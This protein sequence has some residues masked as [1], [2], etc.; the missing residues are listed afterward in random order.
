MPHGN[1]KFKNTWLTDE[2]WRSWIAPGKD[3]YHA[4][5][6]FCKTQVKVAVGSKSALKS[7]ADGRDH[8]NLM[9]HAEAAVKS[10]SFLHFKKVPTSSTSNSD[11]PAESP[12][13]S[14]LSMQKVDGLRIP[15][16]VQKAEIRWAIK[17]V[18]SGFSFRSCLNLNSLFQTMF[19]DSEIAK[20]FKMSKTKCAYL[21]N[22]GL[23]PNFKD[24]LTSDISLSPFFSLLFDES[25]NRVLQQEQMDVQIRYWCTKYQIVKSR[26]WDSRFLRPN[27]ENIRDDLLSSVSCLPAEKMHQLS[28]DGP[29]TNWKVLSLLNSKR[30]ESG[31]NPL[32]DAGSCGLHVV[33]GAFQVGVEATEWNLK[34]V[35][36]SMWGLLNESPARRD[37]Y[38][39]V[40]AAEQF[41]LRFCPTRWVENEPVAERAIFLW[42]DYVKLIKH[43]QQL[44]PSYRP[45]NNSSF[46]ALVTAHTDKFMKVKMQIFKDVAS[47]LQ[48]F[49]KSFQTDAPMMPFLPTVL[50][51]LL[52]RVMKLFI[53]ATVVDEQLTALQLVKLD[54]ELPASRIPS[55]K[56]KLLVASQDLLASGNFTS[57]QREGIRKGFAKLLTKMVKKLQERSPLKYHF[58]RC[59][60]S[61]SPVEMARSKD[62]CQAKFQFL[63][64]RMYKLKYISSKQAEDAKVQFQEFL[65]DDVQHNLSE[66]RKYDMYHT[67]LD[68]FLGKFINGQK[69]YEHL[70]NV[71]KFVFVLSH[72]QSNIERGFNVNKEMLEVNLGEKSLYSQRIIYDHMNA[73]G[74]ESHDFE[75][76]RDL[77]LD[78]KAAHSRYT[79]YLEQKK[80]E[81][82]M[83]VQTNKR[84]HLSDELAQVKRSKFDE[85]ASISDMRENADKLMSEAGNQTDLLEMKK[86]VDKSNAFKDSIKKKQVVIG[87]LDKAIVNIE[88][89]LKSIK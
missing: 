35:F 45:K 81:E 15:I 52:R 14:L 16:A 2:K 28:M 40:C 57:D 3:M 41:P 70:W 27:A 80:K 79:T 6:K 47:I 58:V 66:F 73:A 74:K 60:E 61:L 71:C 19:G 21:I 76:G 42:D 72:G 78:C 68:V 62:D 5:C 23:A 65:N 77:M 39:S 43:Y 69:K 44:A 31:L 13:S 56:I 8:K 25:F 48:P 33:S 88:Q 64:A 38:K 87:D 4:Y 18:L 10:L 36:K 55:R 26:Y 17:C 46:D 59:S 1:C 84:K 51:K 85:E 53:R 75:I 86:Y 22:F 30:E 11:A 37:L 12:E 20:S 83:G 29:H 24:I 32:V 89:E 49:L 9:E 7:H 67:R 50:E 82:A 54:V 63:V 34:K